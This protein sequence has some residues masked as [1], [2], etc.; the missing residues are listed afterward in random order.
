MFNPS[1]SILLPTS[2]SNQTIKISKTSNCNSTQNNELNLTTPPISSSINHAL[3]Q[4]IEYNQTT[5]LISNS[6]SHGH[7]LKQSNER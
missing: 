1:K 3:P 2:T 5:S 7:I 6:L 4:N